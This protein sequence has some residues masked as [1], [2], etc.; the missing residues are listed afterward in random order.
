MK[1]VSLDR[2]PVAVV[3]VVLLV[4]RDPPENDPALPNPFRN[5]PNHQLLHTA[6]LP[7]LLRPLQ[8]IKPLPPPNLAAAPPLL[9]T[10]TPKETVIMIEKKIKK[11]KKIKIKI[12]IK[13]KKTKRLKKETEKETGKEIEKEK[14]IEK[15]TE[16]EKEKGIGREREIG[17]EIEIEETGKEMKEKGMMI[18]GEMISRKVLLRKSTDLPVYPEVQ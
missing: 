4:V 12:K 10:E 2:D 17:I 16:K 13:K 9:K 1:V 18:E 14:E 11:E 6:P 7:P 15:K 3:E 5:H 8:T